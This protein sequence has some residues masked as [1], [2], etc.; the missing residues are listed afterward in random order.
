MLRDNY[1]IADKKQ[2]IMD[3]MNDY[4]EHTCIRFVEQKDQYDYINI[5][6]GNG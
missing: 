6:K 2:M 5:A 4:H 1:F 3:A